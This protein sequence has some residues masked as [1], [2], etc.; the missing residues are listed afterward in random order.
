M[1]QAIDRFISTKDIAGLGKIALVMLAA[2]VFNNLFQ[3][4][5]NWI[6]ARVSQDA[7]KNLRHELF[8]HLQTLSIEFYD[9]HPAGGLMSRLTNDIDAINQAVS[10]NI[11]S[12]I[13][14]ILTMVGILIAMFLLNPWL[15]LSTLLVVPIMLWFTEF[16]AK[17][18]RNGFRQLQKNL[19]SLN[20]V[21]EEAISG[22]KVVKA[23]HRN[24]SV[25]A[26]FRVENEAVFKAGGMP[27]PM[28]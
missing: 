15:A 23:F 24:E 8:A 2:Y 21:A 13:A 7:L 11:T 25:I 6:M 14:S 20:A 3:A 1:G 4:L 10:Q 27:T 26:A 28:P 18:T 5:A 22:Q 19:G 16:V 12:L 17:Y 9:T